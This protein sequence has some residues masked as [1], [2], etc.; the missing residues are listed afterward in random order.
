ML[1]LEFLFRDINKTEMTNEGKEFV[2]SRLKDPAFTSFSSCKYKSEINLTKIEQMALNNLSN[3][4]NIVIQMSG[5]GSS[6]V[7]LDKGEYLEGMSKIL[8]SKAK[9]EMF[10]VDRDKKLN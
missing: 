3:N 1:L 4:K 8:N 5:K 9:F 6:V 7:R 10:Q 2:K